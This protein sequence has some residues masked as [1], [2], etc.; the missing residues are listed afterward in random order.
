[1][2]HYKKYYTTTGEV[3]YSA[4]VRIK[5]VKP[6]CKSFARLTDAKQW[7]YAA[8]EKARRQ[9]TGLPS[10][11]QYTVAEAIDRYMCEHFPSISNQSIR[12]AMRWWRNHLGD[13]YLQ[14]VKPSEIFEA[15]ELISKEPIYKILPSGQKSKPETNVDG[16]LKLRKPKTVQD[17]VNA[18][19]FVYNKAVYEWEWL[20]KN[21]CDRVKRLKISNER[22]RF[23][24]DYLHLWPNET[25]A[26]RWDDLTPDEKEEARVKFPRAYELPR[27]IEA[28]TAQADMGKFRNNHPYWGYYLFVI[29]L[30]CGLRRGEAEHLVWEE[31]KVID[32]PIVIV[33][34]RREVLLLK[35]T[36]K[37]QSPRIKPICETAMSVLRELYASRRYDTPLVFPNE[38]GTKPLNFDKRIRKAIAD[39]GLQDFRWHDLRHTTASYLSMMGAGQREIMEALHHKTLKASQR[40]QHLTCD[41]MRGMMNKFTDKILE[42]KEAPSRF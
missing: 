7:A 11:E 18:L 20:D 8:T 22:T 5:G 6:F 34:M 35:S 9:A 4:E 31:N 21:P 1:M 16:S 37:D 12:S 3:R 41:H 19:S 27:L 25:E 15:R 40:Y 38:A 23:L 26:R 13:R 29:Q 24:S 32:H 30:G 10:S 2:A 14:T 17:Y 42:E 33:D 36:K 39:A 28:L